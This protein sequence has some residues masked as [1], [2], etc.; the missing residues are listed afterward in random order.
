MV[1]SLFIIGFSA[2][3]ANPYGDSSYEDS[4][5]VDAVEVRAPIKEQVPTAQTNISKVVIDALGVDNL[6]DITTLV[7][8]LFIADYGSAMTSPIYLRGVGARSSS[9]SV[10]IYVNGVPILNQA[11]FDIDRL[12][13]SSIEVLRGPQGTLYGRN[14][15]GGV[16]NIHTVSP[17]DYQGINIR[18][19]A[20]AYG[21]YLLDGTF[22]FKL[23]DR[24]GLGVSAYINT[25]DGY[26]TNAHNGEKIDWRNNAGGALTF[27]WDFAPLWRAEFSANFDITRGGAFP[28]GAYDVTTGEIAQPNFNSP[29]NYSRNSSISSLRLTRTGEKVLFSSTIAYQWFQDD[30]SMDQDFTPASIFNLHQLQQDNAFSGEFTWRST[31]KKM[32]QWSAGLY[33]FYD[34]LHTDATV[35]FGKDGISTILQPVFDNIAANNPN[36]PTM[37]ITDDRIDNPGLYQTPSW[38]VAAFGS[39]TLKDLFVDGLSLTTG[40]RLDYEE[41]SIDYDTELAMNLL[42]EVPSP[43]VPPISIVAQTTLNGTERQNSFEWL[44]RASLEYR[45]ND[46]IVSW[47]TASKGY[48]AGGY[49][50]QMFS[51]IAQRSLQ[52]KYNP[53]AT[54]SSID[55]ESTISYSPEITWNYEIGSR[56]HLWQSRVDLEAVLFFMDI[57]DLQITEFVEGGSGRILSNAGEAASYGVELSAS[58]RP[59]SRINALRFDL[60]YGYTHAKFTNYNN[61]MVDYSGNYIPYTPR[62]TFSATGIYNIPIQGWI[63]NI[64]ISASYSGAGKIFW[65]DANNIAQDYY[66]LFDAKVAFQNSMISIELWADNILNTEYGAFYFESFGNSFIERGA[67]FTFGANVN[68]TF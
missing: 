55:L 18:T 53:N 42:V 22:N 10:A 8:N 45:W 30:M 20:A 64:A 37:T 52:E 56:A 2:Y 14:A 25:T 50:V 12:G 7:P 46:E 23:G 19:S 47:F 24:I 17:L 38:G 49:N 43:Q 33:G 29:S 58:V 59:L 65:T 35:G 51:E 9:S 67:P 60:N 48:K 26:F 63:N 34:D 15:M 13:I 27:A 6:K 61:G 41:Q 4:L 5:V 66:G 11:L 32:V 3:G 1:F 68:F 21:T 57:T 62:H 40:V 39:L 31:T 28:Y 36:A 54:P 44:P 16:V